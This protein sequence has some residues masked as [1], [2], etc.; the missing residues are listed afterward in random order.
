MSSSEADAPPVTTSLT[1]RWVA[2]ARPTP[3]ATSSIVAGAR[4]R[5]PRDH[6]DRPGPMTAA[7][8]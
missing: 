3:C 1:T 4:D 2:D 6:E 8:G 5:Q 7:T